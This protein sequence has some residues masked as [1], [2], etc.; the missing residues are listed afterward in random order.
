[1]MNFDE[2]LETAKERVQETIPDAEVKIQQV[3]KLQ[4]ESYR[5][6]FFRSG[7]S[8]IEANL[9]GILADSIYDTLQPGIH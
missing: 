9:N 8:P 5:G 2:F 7:D 3:N 4:G 6:L 1:M